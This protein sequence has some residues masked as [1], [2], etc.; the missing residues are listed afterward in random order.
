MV[1]TIETLIQVKSALGLWFSYGAF[2]KIQ[3]AKT[4][5]THTPYYNIM[6]KR[7]KLI[8]RTNAPSCPSARDVHYYIYAHARRGASHQIDI[9]A[10]AVFPSLKNRYSRKFDKSEYTLCAYRP[11]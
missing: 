1:H 9:A 6:Q 11:M 7:V 3:S 8:M 10:A 4:I 5:T 2:A